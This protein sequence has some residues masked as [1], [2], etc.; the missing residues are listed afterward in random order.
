MSLQSDVG[1]FIANLRNQLESALSTGLSGLGGMAQSVGTSVSNIWGGGFAGMK[2][3]EEFVAAV[4]TYSQQVHAAVDEYNAAADLDASFKGQT[5]GA[6]AEFVT[7]TKTL[8]NA[9]VKLVDKWADEA[10]AAYTA[11]Q[12]G[13]SGSVAANV[14]NASAD[15]KQM[16]SNISLD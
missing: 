14:Q 16:A 10:R 3:P 13:D 9:W 7:D 15:I 11:W 6:L 5:Q 2:D 12:E 1:N 8:L 4:Q